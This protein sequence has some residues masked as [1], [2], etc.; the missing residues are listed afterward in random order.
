MALLARLRPQC[1]R[2]GLLWADQ[3]YTGALASWRWGLRPWRNIRLDMVKR[4]AGVKG[5]LLLP[6][7]WVVERS[8]L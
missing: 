4:P 6:Q 1:S 7:R 3:A 5:F 8:Y 2:L